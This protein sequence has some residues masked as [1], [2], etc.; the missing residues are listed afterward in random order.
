MPAVFDH[1]GVRFQYPESW[2]LEA[3][4]DTEGSD[5]TLYSPGGAFGR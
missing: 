3:A 2:E 5:V 4:D 1:L